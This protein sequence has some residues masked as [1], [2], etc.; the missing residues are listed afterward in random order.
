M[1]KNL[2]WAFA[3]AIAAFTA[4]IPAAAQLEEA[5]REAEGA[6]AS[7]RASQDRIDELDEARGDIFRE[8]RATLQRID[9][10]QLFVDQQRVF[11]ESQRNDLS[12]LERQIE[13]VDDITTSLLPMQ[14]DMI[15]ALAEFIELDLPFLL[16]DR[17]ARV[18]RLREVMNNRNVSAAERYRLILEAY[19][20]ETDYGRFLNTYEGPLTN[21]ENAATVDFLMIGRLAFIYQTQ[22]DSE[23]GIWDAEA[24]DWRSLDGGFRPQIRQA[25]RMADEVTT[26]NVFL[27]PVPGPTPADGDGES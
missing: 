9:S 7:A 2:R 19:Q 15:D 21:D 26:P 10:Q 12:D 14:H 8:Y 24:G 25:I 27:A 4:A 13:E 5:V 17:R 6:T 22:D 3:G 11:L 20:I 16:D 1:T 18:E 23:A